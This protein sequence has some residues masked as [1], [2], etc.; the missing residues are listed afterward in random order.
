MEKIVVRTKFHTAHRQIGYPGHCQ[1]IHGHTWR[2][3]ITVETE[4]FP[5]DELDMS[6]DF[7]DLKQV[8]RFLDHKIVVSPDDALMQDAKLFDPDGVVVVPGRG[9]SVE[10]VA[11]WAWRRVV[12]LI[13]SKYPGRG[14]SYRIEVSIQETDNN[15]FAVTKSAVV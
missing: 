11:V 13:A 10:N 7:A 4:E 2:G 14:K 3:T 12:D 9:P 6:L 1:W 8:L 15:C 5:R